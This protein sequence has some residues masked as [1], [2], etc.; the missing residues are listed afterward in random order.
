MIRYIS[1]YTNSKMKD[2]RFDFLAASTKIEY[3][4]KALVKENHN[5]E[6]IS[7]SYSV[8]KFLKSSHS[9][10][11]GFDIRFFSSL[12][13]SKKILR[14]LNRL[15]LKFQLLYYIILKC[16]KDDVLLVYHSLFYINTIKFIKKIKKIKLIL[17]IEEIYGDVAENKK[18]SQ[19]ELDYFTIP[20]DIN[21]LIEEIRVGPNAGEDVLKMIQLVVSAKGCL[22]PVDASEL[23]YP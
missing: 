22:F 14:P 21:T 4:I 11:D 6:V 8:D 2:K 7:T 16:S 15:W 5:V 13:M 20:I 17:E 3:V 12:D 23:L 9:R 10:L 1:F 19:K 18:I